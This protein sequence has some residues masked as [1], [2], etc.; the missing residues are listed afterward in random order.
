MRLL[1]HIGVFCT[2]A[3]L[4]IQPVCAD[5]PATGALRES[6]VVKKVFDNGLTVLIKEAHSH[7]TVSME[8]RFRT[9]SAQEAGFL[10]SGISHFVEHMLFKGTP[11]RGHGQI[12]K[13][14]KSY[15]GV[16]NGFTSFD[17]TGYSLSV[18]STY[19]KEGLALLADAVMNPSFD[20]TE[21][22]KEREVILKEIKL[23][24]D[25]PS[26]RAFRLLFSNAYTTHPYR[27]PVIGYEPIFKKLKREDLR[28]YHK[29]NYTPANLVL[30][31][32]GDVDTG[33][34]L[35]EIENLFKGYGRSIRRPVVLPEEPEQIT[36]REYSQRA[37]V[38]LARL[39]I[40]Y[41]SI[42]IWHKDL[43]ALD[44]LASILGEG[45]SSLLHARLVEEERIAH[46]VSAFNYTPKDPGVFFISVLLDEENVPVAVKAIDEEIEKIK[47][48]RIDNSH[49]EKARNRTL[50]SFILGHETVTAQARDLVEGEILV[51]NPSFSAHYLKGIEAAEKRDI[52]SVANAYLKEDARTIVSLLPEATEQKPIDKAGQ[53]K[54]GINISKYRL[55]NGMSVLV[56]EDHALPIVYIRAVLKGGVRVESIDTNGLSNMTAA[57]LL[58]GTKRRTRQEIARSVEEAGGSVSGFSGNNSFGIGLTLLSKDLDFGLGLASDV[59]QNSSFPRE[60]FDKTKDLLL[61]AVKNREDDIFESGIKLFKE[62]LFRDHPYRFT[63]LGEAGS[64]G[65]LT[66]KD[67]VN[68]YREFCVPPNCVL[69]VFGDVDAEDAIQK[70]ERLFKNFKG[71][72]PAQLLDE[73]MEIETATVRDRKVMDKEQVLVI[74]GLKTIQIA[75]PDRYAFSVLSSILSGSDGRFFYDVR[76]KLGISYTQ[77][78]SS[79]PGLDTG[80]F[81]FYI[82]TSPEHAGLAKELI[83]EE[84]E[85]L[86]EGSVTEEELELAKSDLI[87]SHIRQMQSNSGLAFTS[88]LDELYGLGFENFKKFVSETRSVTKEDIDRIVKKYFDPRR[89]T[90][91]TLG[92]LHDTD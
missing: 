28:A 74:G 78:V 9:G 61:A 41:R 76:D 6:E 2:L 54:D 89:L 14:V 62:N 50:T 47:A 51:G 55:K 34:A 72:M 90:I 7:P 26:K 63:V 48:G 1:Y 88:S 69:A 20:E 79:A 56:R 31:I 22:E 84:I 91:V 53:T 81:L 80:Y 12:E 15:G 71:S 40:G 67:C 16:I 75:D 39:M 8:A 43:F 65:G 49:I 35:E 60:E 64:V 13:E 11:S 66:R 52:V 10:G 32:C 44:V 4:L 82:A 59:L 38:Q 19:F 37:P 23:N 58:K 70:I 46:S 17:T 57:M 42:E 30:G 24:K 68:F 29:K 18:E 87:G 27:H 3:I 33:I 21:I 85:K 25:N 5:E 45:D 73:T 36:E 92:P 86:K 77:G 83:A